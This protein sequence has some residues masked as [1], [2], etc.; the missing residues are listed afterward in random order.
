MVRSTRMS[1]STERWSERISSAQQAGNILAD[2]AENLGVVRFAQ[3]IHLPFGIRFQF[4]GLLD[5]LLAESAPV[6][7]H[8]QQARVEQFVEQD[9][10]VQQV[11]RRPG[12]GAGDARHLFEALR[13]LMQQGE[14]GR[15]AADGLEQ[16]EQA[17]QG[18]VAVGCR[19]SGLDG[20]RH[21][22][23]EAAF[24]MVAHLQVATAG[25]DGG[26]T[27]AQ[28]CRL[29]KAEFFQLGGL[30][31]GLRPYR[32]EM[33]I[34]LVRIGKHGF[35]MACDGLAMIVQFHQQAFIVG[36][37]H[38]P[39][40]PC[41][42]LRVFRQ[43]MGLRIVEILQA[44]F[45]AAQ[46]TIGG[47]EFDDRVE[48][49]LVAINEQFQDLQRRL[50]L[51]AAVAAAANQL[52]DLGDELDF[53]DAAGAE[54][55]VVG[56][57][58]LRDFAA[59]LRMQV[60]HGIDGAEIEVL[61]E[62]EGAADGLQ[63]V[64]VCSC[65]RGARLDPGIALPFAALGDEVVFQH[66]EGADQWPG[67]AIRPQAHID[68]EHLAV[69]GDFGDGADQRLADAGKELEVRDGARPRR[70][71]IFGVDENQVD[72]GR[73]IQLAAAQFAHAD[74]NQLLPLPL[75]ILRLPVAGNEGGFAD[76]QGGVHGGFGDQRHAFDDLGQV[77]ASIQVAAGDTRHRL[78]LEAAQRRFQ[79]VLG[80]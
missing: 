16:V 60:A 45:E 65:Q 54:L 37:T 22:R 66:L 76:G 1:A 55:D 53:A 62:H 68:A 75:G 51:Q 25:A 74:D 70:V 33:M 14:V 8:F 49:E 23:I 71:A 46:E 80:E 5:E 64:P 2:E 3:G 38:G 28:G 59:D 12:R 21:Q 26:E 32:I 36:E 39:G 35:E 34:L 27:G 7:R 50:D 79:C 44:M 11:I 63:I 47:R 52:E 9:R 42:I 4:V 72:I 30:A 41:L 78:L 15:T 6:G 69:A 31:V 18:F 48:F 43:G 20:A 56:H 57:V 73:D 40:D 17:R 77:G 58:L 29:A 10:V 19:R 67:I 24:R 61:A 13:I